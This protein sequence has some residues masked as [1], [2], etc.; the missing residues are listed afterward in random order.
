MLHVKR[1]LAQRQRKGALSAE[2]TLNQALASF[3]FAEK[4][5]LS[6]S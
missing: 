6:S 3:R 4:A 1:T 5:D 2:Q